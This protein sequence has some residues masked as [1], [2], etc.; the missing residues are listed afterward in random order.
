V[1]LG[2]SE[3]FKGKSGQGMYGDVVM[4]IDWS[5]GEILAALKKHGLDDQTLVMFSS[6]N[7]PWLNYG[8]HAGSA[9]PLRE[10]KGTSW[11]G[12]VREPFIARWPG[13]VS[14]GV[15]C[16]EWAATIDILPTLAK[17]AGAE[18]PRLPIDGL[19]VSPLLFGTPGAKT[20]HAAYFY[21]WDRHLQ[22]VRSGKWKLHFPHSYRTLD[23]QP[24]GRDGKPVKYVQKET[25]LA[26]YD[27]EADPGETTDVAKQH[28]DTV[29]KLKALADKEREE[30]GD[31][32]TKRQGKGVRKPGTVAD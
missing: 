2:V 20:P 3:K 22:A 31:S 14:A 21:Y 15:V 32:V 4:E 25:G 1:P 26:L 11:E 9:G 7:G 29:E 6:D 10:G 23:G 18:L 30:L 5:V 12:G 16:K 8:N 17:L 24:G 13:K 28:S 19:D 27:L